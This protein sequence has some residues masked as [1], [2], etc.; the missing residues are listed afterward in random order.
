MRRAA[1]LLVALVLAAGARAA[2]TVGASYLNVPLSVRQIGMGGVSTGGSDLLRAW[3]NPAVLADQPTRGQAALTGAS[4]YAGQFTTIGSGASWLLLPSWSLGCM[5]S[6]YAA[7]YESVDEYGESRGS[8]SRSVSSIG[9]AS[10]WRLGPVRAGV[11]LKMVNDSVFKEAASTVAADLGMTVAFGGVT[12]GI[13]YRNL[14]PALRTAGE[15]GTYDESLPTELRGGAAY[16]F[17][18]AHVSAG[19]ELAAAAGE[20]SRI[21]LG[22]EW[23]PAPRFA[24]RGGTANLSEA[25]GQLTLGLSAELNAFVL[26]YAMAAHPVGLT[27]KVSVGYAFG[28]TAADFEAARRA[29]QPPDEP[30]VERTPP[31]AELPKPEAPKAESPKSQAGG[32]NVAVGDLQAQGV[33]PTDAAVISDMLRSELIKTGKVNVIEKSNMD[34]ILAEQAFQQTG[35]TTSECAVKLGKLLNARWMVVG[36]VG[37]MLGDYYLSVRV[38]DVETGKSSYGDTAKA[39]DSSGVEKAIRNFAKAI[40]NTVK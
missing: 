17:A 37:K 21:A 9:L 15:A 18:A 19:A 36:S 30:V 16:K 40:A 39:A 23:R 26:D 28:P 2:K 29:T 22:V 33:S 1:V 4:A 20:P 24:V 25:G 13:A 8:E 6:G 14:G 27:H 31:A 35:C 10:A 5:Y 7:N 12:A 11:T 32:R 3:S 34:R 38:I